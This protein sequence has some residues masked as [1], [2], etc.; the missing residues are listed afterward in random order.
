MAQQ[1]IHFFSEDV[2]YTL[3]NKASLRSWIIDTISGENKK[4][5]ELS[6]ILCSDGYLLSVNQQYLKHDTY[7]DIITFDYS[8]NPDEIHGDIF[9]S[10]ERVKENALQIGHAEKDELHRVI[11]HGVLHLLGYKDKS[12]SEQQ[13][14]TSKEDQ[15]LALRRF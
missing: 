7:T 8:E 11:I 15:Y 6:I 12:A 4:L 14:M 9:I 2:S 13:L 1:K 10:I 5:K 3:K